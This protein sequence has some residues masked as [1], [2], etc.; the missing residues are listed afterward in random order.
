[1]SPSGGTG[2][3]SMTENGDVLT[4]KQV[5][6]LLHMAAKTLGNWRREGK[7]PPYFLVGKRIRYRRGSLDNWMRENEK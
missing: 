2:E 7:G 6:V 4:E 5:A 3:V 1:M